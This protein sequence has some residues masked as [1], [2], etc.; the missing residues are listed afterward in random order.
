MQTKQILEDIYNNDTPYVERKRRYGEGAL[1]MNSGVELTEDIYCI[2]YLSML[3]ADH[4]SIFLDI[5]TGHVNT[6]KEKQA[7]RKQLLEK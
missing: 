3:K 5:E 6:E 4:I 7:I 2:A 1:R